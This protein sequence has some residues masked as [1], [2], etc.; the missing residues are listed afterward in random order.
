MIDGNE[1]RILAILPF[2][3]LSL[4]TL[5]PL[6]YEYAFQYFNADKVVIFKSKKKYLPVLLSLLSI[7][8]SFIFLSDETYKII[9]LIVNVLSLIYVITF[10]ILLIRYQMKTTSK[11]KYFYANLS[12][13]NLYWVNILIVGFVLVAILDLCSAVI[14]S[15]TGFTSIPI[16]NTTFLLVLTWYLGY[17]GFTQQKLVNNIH[18][19]VPTPKSDH[20]KEQCETDE[21]LE[22]RTKLDSVIKDEQLYKIEGV[23]L[24][25]LSQYL[26]TT[27]KKTSYLLNQCMNTNFYDLINSFRLNDF[28]ERVENGELSSKT[29]LA[30][31][32]DAGFNS[33]ASFNRIFKQQVGTSP[34]KYAKSIKSL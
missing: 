4:M 31:A 33:K 22:L 27:E 1:K 30:L 19:Y 7:L 9:L 20:R 6:L 15:S 12:D 26:E 2:T 10:L 18:E 24:T 13:K 3:S 11:L 28:K 34:S 21:Y 32:L 5:G 23:N 17:Y 25:M 8:L 16:I 14:L 29:I